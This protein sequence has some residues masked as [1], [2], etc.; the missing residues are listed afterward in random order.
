MA[1]RQIWEVLSQSVYHLAM[2]E[3][4]DVYAPAASSAQPAGERSIWN[5]VWKAKL[6][7]KMK[8]AAW[9]VATGSLP[10]RENLHHRNVGTSALCPRCAKEEEMVFHD[11]ILCEYA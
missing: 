11:V 5:L 7:Q 1:T 4:E 10:T 9:R 3:H 2:Q 8:I 6:P